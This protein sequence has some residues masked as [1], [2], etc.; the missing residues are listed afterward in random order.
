MEKPAGAVQS[1]GSTGVE[2]VNT[3]APARCRVRAAGA[4]KFESPL[5]L[6]VLVWNGP[7]EGSTLSTAR[8]GTAEGLYILR[9]LFASIV[10]E[11]SLSQRAPV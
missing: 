10:R 4:T 3:T 8:V 2:F 7:K 1:H 5:L 9:I 6:G 11:E